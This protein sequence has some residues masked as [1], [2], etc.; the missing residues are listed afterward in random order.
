MP[1][2]LFAKS[3]PP[4]PVPKLSIEEAVSLASEYFY[5]KE[6][7]IRG[8]EYFKKS[9]YIL[10]SAEYTNRLKD[11]AGHE[12]AWKIKFVHPE[13]NDHSVVYKVTDEGEVIYLYG[14]E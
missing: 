6:T 4:I 3:G 8:Q 11:K 5:T 1:A 7:R 10:I 13:Q 9:D 2:G 14:S 12:W